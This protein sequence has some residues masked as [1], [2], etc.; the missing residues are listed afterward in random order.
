MAKSHRQNGSS[1]SKV[2]EIVIP[3]LEKFIGTAEYRKAWS[4][5]DIAILTKYYQADVPLNQIAKYLKRSFAAVKAK[6]GVLGL[7][8]RFDE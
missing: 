1:K 6:V 4:E 7:R 3:E 5:K 2:E 8:R